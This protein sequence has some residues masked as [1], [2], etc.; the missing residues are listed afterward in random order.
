M[1]VNIIISTENATVKSLT[2]IMDELDLPFNLVNS[3]IDALKLILETDPGSIFLDIDS[4]SDKELKYIK[5]IKRVSPRLPIIGIISKD[6]KENSD[7]FRNAGINDF[8]QKP[9]DYKDAVEQVQSFREF[10]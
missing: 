3:R 9:I 2:A 4:N 8:L 7:F 5:T 6:K 10:K 1:N